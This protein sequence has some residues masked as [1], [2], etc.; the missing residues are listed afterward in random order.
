MFVC[1]FDQCTEFGY[2]RTKSGVHRMCTCLEQIMHKAPHAIRQLGSG[3]LNLCYVA[4]GR[5]DAVYAG[6]AGTVI[7]CNGRRHVV[8]SCYDLIL[9]VKYATLLCSY[10]V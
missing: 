9:D 5:Q 2:D 1:L 4:C 8:L 6:V 3:V 10:H 7:Y